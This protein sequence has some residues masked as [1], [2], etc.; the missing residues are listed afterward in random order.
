MTIDTKVRALLAKTIKSGATPGEQSAAVAKARELVN[1]HGL[2]VA[3]FTW[4][5]ESAKAPT[6]AVKTATA[7][8]APRRPVKP[9]TKPAKGPTRGDQV[10]EQL[11]RRNGATI[12]EMVTQFGLLPHSLRAIISVESRRRGLKVELVGGRY[13][14][15]AR[16]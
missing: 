14:A 4:P 9:A 15:T 5:R 13:R 11:R 10:V 16:S 6:R 12:A 3:T 1:K 2:N 7:G 8:R